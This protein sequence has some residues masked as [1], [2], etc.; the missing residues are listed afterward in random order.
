MNIGESTG[1]GDF[2][3]AWLAADLRKSA[4][5]R[6][7]LADREREE[8]ETALSTSSA[9]N[10]PLYELTPE[11][12]PLPTFGPRLRAI[13]GSLERGCGVALVR[14]LP[15]RTCPRRWRGV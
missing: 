6:Y 5:W 8:V 9:A 7:E 15:M 1:R 14:G 2:G 13:V 11:D 4:A 12:F 3:Q 10:K